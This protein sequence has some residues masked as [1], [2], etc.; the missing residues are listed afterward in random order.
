MVSSTKKHGFT[1]IEVMAALAVIGFIL[2]SLSSLQFSLTRTTLKATGN[3]D[4]TWAML[5]FLQESR[6]KIET[7][8]ST[9]QTKTVPALSLKLRYS[10]SKPPA[11]SKLSQ[12]KDLTIERVEAIGPAKD[13]HVQD[14]LVTFNYNA[15]SHET[16]SNT[17]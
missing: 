12:F 6:Q 3:F 1:L 2:T 16:R 17:A 10:R 11:S 15:E 14:T 9:E 5:S 7:G 8:E 4:R 13:G